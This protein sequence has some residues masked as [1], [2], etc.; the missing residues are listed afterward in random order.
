[1]K[2]EEI[3]F[4]SNATSGRYTLRTDNAVRDFIG[5][6]W[7]NGYDLVMR[8]KNPDDTPELRKQFYEEVYA[9]DLAGTLEEVDWSD[10]D[11]P[12]MQEILEERYFEWLESEQE[13]GTLE[14]KSLRDMWDRTEGKVADALEQVILGNF[15]D[16]VTVEGT[17]AQLLLSATGLDVAADVR[18]IAADFYN[19]EWSAEH[20]VQT[21]M[22]AAGLIPIVGMIKS[23]DEVAS[24]IKK[25]TG[26]FKYWNK[27]TEFNGTKV[28][29]RDDLIDPNLTDNLG[30]T[31][32]ER[33]KQ[34]LA[35]IGPDGKSIN[36]H[37]TIQTN[38]SPVAEV[39]Q[40]FHK[41][42]HS[43]IH[44]NPNTIPS[45]I[46][47]AEFDKWRKAYWKNRANDFIDQ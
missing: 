37:H 17:A 1:M 28:Y 22:D 23:A 16:T 18:D 13:E 11:R 34:G 20:L 14:K 32:L 29:Q 31:N 9:N 12:S 25:G 35:P 4:M 45:G 38:D 30:R 26:D 36:L 42:S 24:L 10:P 19:W 47:R 8:R 33:M 43:I 15:T 2:V 39:I 41:D 21:G 5:E 3:T 6:T 46:N 7:Q 40:T 27:T 44:I